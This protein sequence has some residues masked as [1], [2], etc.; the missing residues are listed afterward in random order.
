VVVGRTSAHLENPRVLR[1][2]IVSPR[3]RS[4]Y[5]PTVSI[6]TL[7]YLES[8]PLTKAPC[9]G[10]SGCRNADAF[11]KVVE[12]FDLIHRSLVRRVVPKKNGQRHDSLRTTPAQT[13]PRVQGD[14][15]VLYVIGVSGLVQGAPKETHDRRTDCGPTTDGNRLV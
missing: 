4:S 3:L 15:A 11:P 2:E 9:R 12:I 14:V 7:S 8:S 10:R 13:G 1:S 5:A 6:R